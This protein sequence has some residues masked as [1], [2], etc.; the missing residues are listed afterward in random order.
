MTLAQN[1]QL[2]L[3]GNKYWIL[4]LSVLFL[5]ACSPKIRTESKQ[6]EVPKEVPKTEKPAAK[7]EQASISLL[8]PFRL[9][10]IR[11]KTATKAEV[12][13]A[14]MAIDFYQGFKLGIDSAAASGQNFKLKV[15]DTQD[16][17]AQIGALIDNGGL[18]GSNLIV[19]PVF[20]EGLKYIT[21]Y[22]ISRN[23]PV[24]NPLSAAHPD[25]FTNPNLIS[26]VNNVDQ[27]AAKIG[28]YISKNYN[29][30]NTVVVLI[31]P[32]G[33]SDEVM[34]KPLR[35]YFTE[36]NKFSFQ[37]YA[38]VFTMEPKIVKGKQYVIIVS[39]SDRKFVVP[40][41]DKLMK[42]R[43]TGLNISVFGHPDWIKQN[44]NTEQLQ[45]LN[46]IISSSYK[47][48]YTRPEVNTFIRKYRASFNFEPGEYSF[49]GFDIG[50]YF[51]KL[52]S[53]YGVDYLK[54]LTKE[55]YKGLHNSFRFM[56]NNTLGYINT[57]LMLLKYKNFALN[58]VE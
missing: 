27:H 55:R 22:S 52:L 32:K 4:I 42:I 40:T 25:E 20:P 47:I 1:H 44:Y 16:N 41:L 8:A 26:I 34:A 24:V 51:G 29:P 28:S 3:S 58:I 9:N 37:E 21:N 46:T 19:G 23:I 57:S 31:N 54:Y 30:A 43:K 17:N 13:R 35:A 50:F 39:S 18:M 14:A 36:R 2:L 10:E 48:D 33:S 38:S 6:P 49:K 45:A 5:S 15:Y 12:E 7:F 11:L 56:H 53:S